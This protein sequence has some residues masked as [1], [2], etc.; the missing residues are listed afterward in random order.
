MFERGKERGEG[1]KVTAREVHNTTK[2]DGTSAVYRLIYKTV[3]CARGWK[4]RG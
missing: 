3:M 2:K 1:G 4:G